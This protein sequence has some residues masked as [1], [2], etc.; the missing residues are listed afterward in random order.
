MLILFTINLLAGWRVHRFG[1]LPW[2]LSHLEDLGSPKSQGLSLACVSATTLDRRP[3]GSSRVRF[4]SRM[5]LCDQ[6]M[7]TIDH[8][9]C[10][11]P[12]S[13]EVWFHV[14]QAISLDLPASARSVLH[15]W[16]RAAS[17]DNCRGMDSL[18]AL[19]S[20]E[21]WKERKARC[22]RQVAN[23]LPQL[24]QIIKAQADLWAQAR[25]VHLRSLS[26]GE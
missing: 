3:M 5:L 13:R 4:E 9:L 17:A 16:R 26:S 1:P 12:F 21:I 14:C 2:P 25:A 20:W 7:E 19:V 10:K 18:F 22:F 6:A 15:W 8:L 11:C 23:L 24:L